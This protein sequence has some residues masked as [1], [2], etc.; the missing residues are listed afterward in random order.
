MRELGQAQAG[1]QG[2][3]SRIGHGA[4]IVD[5]LG[6]PAKGKG[7]GLRPGGACQVIGSPPGGAQG[8]DQ[9]GDEGQARRHLGA[10]QPLETL[11]GQGTQPVG[12]QTVHA[13]SQ[14]R[15]LGGQPVGLAQRQLAHIAKGLHV[16]GAPGATHD[17]AGDHIGQAQQKQGPA[18]QA[19]Y[20]ALGNDGRCGLV[21][22][23][24]PVAAVRICT[25]R[26]GESA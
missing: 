19:A 11:Q 4:G 21:H 14:A 10:E 18:R 12:K 15:E 16:V 13:G 17:K 24:N 1:N 5:Q 23:I 7:H 20:S 6:F 26:S 2:Q 25:A 9:Q 22:A 8:H 3:Q